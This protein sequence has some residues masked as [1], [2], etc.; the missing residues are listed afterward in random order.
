MVLVSNFNSV[1]LIGDFLYSN[2]YLLTESA[3]FTLSLGLNKNPDHSVF[4]K[5]VSFYPCIK[6]DKEILHEF[7][8][9]LVPNKDSVDKN[10][11]GTL[12]QFEN[13]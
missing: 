9:P 11:K 10:E 2:E 3:P 12:F 6:R 13:E 1:T 4:S 7:F 8:E 5:S